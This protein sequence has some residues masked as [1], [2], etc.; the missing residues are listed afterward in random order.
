LERVNATLVEDRDELQAQ[1]AATPC[2]RQ[3]FVIPSSGRNRSV[4]NFL[5]FLSLGEPS[6]STPSIV[7]ISDDV[8]PLPTLEADQTFL[9]DDALEPAETQVSHE[10]SIPPPE[11]NFEVVLAN[12]S[13]ALSPT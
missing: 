1:R 9:S 13:I 8:T 10:A 6:K 7:Q 2:S 3:K 5:I 11:P 4:K 12:P